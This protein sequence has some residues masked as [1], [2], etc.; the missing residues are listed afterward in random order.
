MIVHLRAAGTGLVLD[1]RGT[2]PPVV[3]HWGDDLGELSGT[4]LAVLA[5]A[6]VPAVPPS[7]PD[8]PLRLSVLPTPAVSPICVSVLSRRAD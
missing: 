3:V 6:A 7:A 2:R 4:D 1:A 5:D 8:H